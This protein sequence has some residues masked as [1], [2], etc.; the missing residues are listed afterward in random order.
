MMKRIKTLIKE[1]RGAITAD[2]ITLSGGVMVLMLVLVGT[3]QQEMT[4]YMAKIQP[5]FTVTSAFE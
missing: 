3:V 4:P 1:D 2:W 5:V